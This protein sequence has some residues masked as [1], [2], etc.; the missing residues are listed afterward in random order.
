MTY[1]Q[2]LEQLYA[3]LPAFHRI[4]KAALKPGLDNTLALLAGLGNPHQKFASIHIA[5]TN[6]KGSSSHMLASILQAA[7]YK[8]GLYTS[9]H[10]KDY[11]ERI[12]INGQMIPQER[13]VR[14]VREELPGLTMDVEPSFFEAT[15]AL[16]FAWFAEER[17]DIA[18]IETGLGGRLDSTNVITPLASLITNIGWDHMDL[19]GNTLDQIAAEKAGIIKPGR[20]VVISQRQV[21]TTNV[22]VRKA[23]E[24]SSTLTF[25]DERWACTA[26]HTDGATFTS[27]RGQEQVSF[28]PDLPGQYQIHNTLGVLA[29]V[30]ELRK[31]GYPIS[32]EDIEKGLSQ[33]TSQTG[34]AGR[35]QVLRQRPLVV[36]DTAHNSN[37]LAAVLEQAQRAAEA[38]QLYIILGVVGDKDLDRLVPLLPKA[39]RYTFAE[40]SVFRKLPAE[41]LAARLRAEGL[42][43]DIVQDVNAALAKALAAAKPEDVVLIT[44]STFLVADLT[45]IN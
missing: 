26:W 6:G 12:R 17:P 8:T 13:V 21:E 16:C 37:G 11:R 31:L 42:Q 45:E 1:G 18:V 41:L 33:V 40:P 35:W 29:M 32:T 30:D 34:L 39:A 23:K 27:L 19:L 10:L 25:A 2:A 9:P 36:A 4:G 38:G 15:V 20:P 5:G 22:F 28:V 43:G 24:G 7:G 14:F 44:G 3:K